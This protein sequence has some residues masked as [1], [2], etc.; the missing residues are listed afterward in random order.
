MATST[1]SEF[2]IAII[3]NDSTLFPSFPSKQLSE[4]DADKILLA[5]IRKHA[6]VSVTSVITFLHLGAMLTISGLIQIPKAEIYGGRQD[7]S[8]G[9][10]CFVVLH[11]FER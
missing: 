6:A 1:W 5:D 8:P 4:G 2:H 7:H 11:V 3:S 9:R 10:H